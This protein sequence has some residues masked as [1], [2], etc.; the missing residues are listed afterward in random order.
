MIYLKA[1]RY[2]IHNNR[3]EADLINGNRGLTGKVLHDAREEGLGEEEPGKPV[4]VGRA[5]VNP[6]VDEVKTILEFL[7]PGGQ[8]LQ[9]IETLGRPDGRDLAVE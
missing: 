2:V 7:G 8:G 9:R 1:Y 5:E 6:L 4:M 3:V